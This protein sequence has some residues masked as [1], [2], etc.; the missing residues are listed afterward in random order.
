LEEVLNLSSDRILNEIIC[1]FLSIV[2]IGE[3]KRYTYVEIRYI[4][5]ERHCTVRKDWWIRPLT[6]NMGSNTLATLDR[7]DHMFE[8]L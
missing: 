2:L 8:S 1:T 5:M 4:L 3:K 6:V 7:R